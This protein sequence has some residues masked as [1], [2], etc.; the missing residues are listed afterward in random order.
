MLTRGLRLA[1][2][3]AAFLSGSSVLGQDSVPQPDQSTTVQQTTD[4]ESTTEVQPLLLVTGDELPGAYGAPG[5]F[6]RSRFSP[7]TT[8]Y[9]LPPGSVY[10]ALIFEG[11]AFRHGPPDHLLSQEIEVGLP[12]RF[13]IAIENRIER[14]AG[15]TENSSLSI[16]GRWALADWGKIPLNPTLFAEYK[17]G[18][19]KILHEEGPPPPPE[20]AEEEEGNGPPDLPDAY[21][22]RL[23]LSQEFGG[24][25]EWAFNAFFE[26]ENTGDRGREWGFAQSI[27]T[28]ILL[29]RERLKAGLEMKYQ[30]FTVKDTRGSP[31][32]RFEIG[33]SFSFKP[34][35]HVRFD[36]APLFGV[37]KDSPR[38]QVFAIFSYVFGGGDEGNEAESP[39]S[40]RNR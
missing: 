11:D 38:V 27:Q 32:H 4:T 3:L 34:A 7:L 33:P 26:K 40:T 37:T 36:L 31:I 8:A 21:E 1:P 17:F 25:F 6:S 16:E 12:Y 23:L 22:F 15:D 19:G 5:A 18:T 29:P 20:E 2:L 35:A 24:R 10:A 39:A 30:N 13:G 28:P 14:F 9:V